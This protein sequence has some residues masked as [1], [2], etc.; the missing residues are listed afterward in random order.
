MITT[1]CMNPCFDKTVE[2]GELKIGQVNRI[3]SARIDLGGKG[4][5]VARV[6]E[7]LG[8]DVQCLGIMG[9]DGSEELT[10][11]IEKEHLKHSFQL[12][13]GHVRTNTKI[14]SGEGKVLQS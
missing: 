3:G 6:A 4:I 9:K 14:V 7:R 11:L 5:N 8:L 10:D 13:P 12:I 1:I 2:V